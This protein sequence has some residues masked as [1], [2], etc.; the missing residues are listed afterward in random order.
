MGAENE[1][2]YLVTRRRSTSVQASGWSLSH[3]QEQ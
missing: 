3:S 2:L 1:R